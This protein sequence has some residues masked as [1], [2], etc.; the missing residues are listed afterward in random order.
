L[1]QLPPVPFNGSETCSEVLARALWQHEDT[2][3]LLS[4]W[5]QPPPHPLQAQ[6]PA[7]DRHLIADTKILQRVQLFEEA[8][9]LHFTHIRLLAQ[10]FCTRSVPFNLIT[11]G[12]NQ[13]FNL[14][15]ITSFFSN[16]FIFS[17]FFHFI[18]NNFILFQ[19]TLFFFNYFYF[20]H[21]FF[22]Y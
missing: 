10:A 17:F 7:G 13:V 21:F 16:Y 6:M 11:L 9:G 14:F 5:S 4:I 20:F 19:I 3:D 18:S 2:M 15:Q 12:D 8:L 1:T 22:K